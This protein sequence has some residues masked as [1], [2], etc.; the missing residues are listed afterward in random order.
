MRPALCTRV[1]LL[2]AAGSVCTLT[3]QGLGIA[4]VLLTLE[5]LRV[6]GVRHADATQG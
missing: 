6:L 5:A 1:H 2:V 4:V 3:A